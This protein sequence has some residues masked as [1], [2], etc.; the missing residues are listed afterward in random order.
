MTEV[1]TPPLKQLQTVVRRCIALALMWLVVFVTTVRSISES[2]WGSMGVLLFVVGLY[3]LH[4][5]RRRGENSSRV[6]Q[7]HAQQ[8]TGPPQP[9]GLVVYSMGTLLVPAGLSCLAYA[10]SVQR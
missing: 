6:L 1:G 7:Q 5:D 8:P 9:A 10:M 4:R 3:A 2:I